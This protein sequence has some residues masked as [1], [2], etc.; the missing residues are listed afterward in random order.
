MV[1]TEEENHRYLSGVSL[2][3]ARDLL[4][5]LPVLDVTVAVES[6]GQQALKVNYTRQEM[7]KV[8]FT[9]VDP[10][11]FCIRCGGVFC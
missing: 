7:K 10:I 3:A 11:E 8:R 1:G 9:F 6:Y 5:L 2:R 4:A